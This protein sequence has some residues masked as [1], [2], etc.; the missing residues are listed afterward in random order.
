MGLF[1][2][3]Q[4]VF[5]FNEHGQ[6]YYLHQSYAETQGVP[7]VAVDA[8]WMAGAQEVG[9][10]AQDSW[11]AGPGLTINAGLRWDEERIRDRGGFT[12]VRL[13]NEWQP[14]LGV[15]WDPWQDGATKLYAFAGRFYNSLA[16]D[17]VA[18]GW[19]GPVASATYNYDPVDLSPADVP[20]HPSTLNGAPVITSPDQGPPVDAG[21]Q[22]VS[23]TSSQPAP[24]DCSGK[25]S[26]SGSRRPIAAFTIRS[27]TV[28][29]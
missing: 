26:R 9:V 23:S 6:T 15:V 12:G 21:L 25:R 18:R 19:G 1:S 2:G 22:G 17:L 10:Y 8:N 28:A 13:Q 4:Q 5:R 24:R 7:P 3:G 16:V 20:G 14:R 27:R 11:K 29:I